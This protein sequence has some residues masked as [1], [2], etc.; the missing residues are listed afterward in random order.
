MVYPQLEFQF[1]RYQTQRDSPER[2]GGY[3]LAEI[4]GFEFKTA[5][6]YAL[7]RMK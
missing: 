1:Q 4:T 6:L 2:G 3:S 5:N 7:F